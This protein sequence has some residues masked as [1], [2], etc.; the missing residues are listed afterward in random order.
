MRFVC[1]SILLS[2]F[3]SY[4]FFYLS[5]LLFWCA[6]RIPSSFS[7][8]I[9]IRFDSIFPIFFLNVVQCSVFPLFGIHISKLIF[10]IFVIIFSFISACGR[11]HHVR[12]IFSFRPT[13]AHVRFRRKQCTYSHILFHLILLGIFSLFRTIQYSFHHRPPMSRLGADNRKVHHLLSE[14]N[15]QSV[16]NS[17]AAYRWLVWPNTLPNDFDTSHAY[18]FRWIEF[19]WTGLP[20]VRSSCAL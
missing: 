16:K 13:T 4:F 10:T 7:D 2:K 18:C 19:T 17:R 9:W 8:P 3:F 5:F 11:R 1:C 20:L 12:A 6:S 14:E 15:L